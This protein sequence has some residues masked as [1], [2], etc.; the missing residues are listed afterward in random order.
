MLEIN[1]MKYLIFFAMSAQQAHATSKSLDQDPGFRPINKSHYSNGIRPRKNRNIKRDFSSVSY[2]LHRLQS[3]ERDCGFN[4]YDLERDFRTS[5]RNHKLN[6][7]VN[8]SADQYCETNY[9][10]KQVKACKTAFRAARL[11]A[12]LR[13]APVATYDGI[14]EG[15]SCGLDRGFEESVNQR[16]YRASLSED[17]AELVYDR[18]A[19]DQFFD[20]HIKNSLLNR[21]NN[22]ANS[23]VVKEFRDKT[24]NGGQVSLEN[25][26][27]SNVSYSGISDSYA[28]AG[29]RVRSK[30]EALDQ[31]SPIDTIGVDEF[32]DSKEDYE[33]SAEIFSYRSQGIFERRYYREFKDS[34]N[35][36]MPDIPR[37]PT[38]KIWAR[39]HQNVWRFPHNSPTRKLAENYGR[40]KQ[41]KIKIKNVD[42][43]LPVEGQANDN[44]TN[45]KHIFIPSEYSVFEEVFNLIYKIRHHNMYYSV[46]LMT[47][48]DTFAEAFEVGEIAGAQVALELEEKDTFNRLMM[49][50]SQS[51][52]NRLV[53]EKYPEYI[54]TKFQE[55]KDSSVLENFQY[56]I[57][58]TSGDGVFKA[59]EEISFSFSIANIGGQSK[60]L[61]VTGAL[62]NQ[63]P[64]VL[65]SQSVKAFQ[66]KKD[67]AIE[68]QLFAPKNSI[69]LS[70]SKAQF[71]VEFVVDGNLV[72]NK[73]LSVFKDAGF[74]QQS[75]I[76]NFSMMRFNVPFQLTNPSNTS[77]NKPVKLNLFAN[78]TLK[79][80]IDF[81]NL[82][83]AS[84]QNLS[85]QVIEEFSTLIDSEYIFSID[86]EVDGKLIQ[87]RKDLRLSFNKTQVAREI[88]FA[89]S[90]KSAAG[91][92]AIQQNLAN[93]TDEFTS[94]LAED[95][96]KEMRTFLNSQKFQN[97]L[98][99]L[100][101][102][103]FKRRRSSYKRIT[104]QW[105]IKNKKIDSSQPS[106]LGLI[107]IDSNHVKSKTEKRDK[108]LPRFRDLDSPAVFQMLGKKLR[109][110]FI[111]LSEDIFNKYSY[112]NGGEHLKYVA[113]GMRAFCDAA[114]IAKMFEVNDS[115]NFTKTRTA[116]IITFVDM[117]TEPEKM[118]FCSQHEKAI[119]VRKYAKG[120]RT[121]DIK[122]NT[123]SSV[124]RMR[125]YA[126]DKD[127]A[128]VFNSYFNRF[129]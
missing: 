48:E 111:Q 79:D 85:F 12:R 106:L 9:H 24:Y 37:N 93:F 121:I 114:L 125:T 54:S 110:N 43:V 7:I 56:S 16:S 65:A 103:N 88:F 73:T 10:P 105:K 116:N 34:Y 3:F 45:P 97:G 92:P 42:Y 81:P 17:L 30:E 96:Y 89:I 102:E 78:G 21:I 100:I 108:S 47:L 8:Q 90:R 124:E 72:A 83:A 127:S 98:P 80:T 5:H 60:K 59:G 32:V 49:E 55:M 99:Y 44:T 63:D 128:P 113:E 18:N 6:R 19:T 91:Y 23:N 57:S 84:R 118:F 119:T 4:I 36:E 104:D 39:I 38:G 62:N 87:S 61:K 129:L 109:P 14:N 115:Y 68:T 33:S 15:I 50:K 126:T 120:R 94:W 22:S 46:L 13:I 112:L 58:E 77:L 29:F 35:V 28:Y 123:G 74:E 31:L 40:L 26:E 70:E 69:P 2:D 53:G 20:K 117:Q 75:P 11:A 1:P 41:E 51:Y 101:S 107:A 122:V 64:K 67:I 71:G 25:I 95:S 66:H 27:A 76:A 52:F 86:L 82:S